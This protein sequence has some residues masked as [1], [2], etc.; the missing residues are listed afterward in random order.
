MTTELHTDYLIVG[1]GAVGMAFAD[2]L[3]AESDADVVII[4]RYERPGG[5]W[6]R[7]YPFVTLH[8][9]SQ[10]YGVRSME[11]SRGL[12]DRVG[13]NRGLYDLA[14]GHEVAAYFD[15]VMRHQ[16]LPTGR[17]RYFPLCDYSGDGNFRH[18]LTGEHYHVDHGMLADCTLLNTSIPSTHTPSFEIEDGVTFMPVNDLPKVTEP[19]AGFVVIGGGKTGID[20]VIWL[21][22]N[23]VDP[24]RITWIMPRD[25]W[26]LDRAKLQPG[27]EFFDATMGAQADQIEAIAAAGSFEDLFHRLEACGYFHRLDPQVEPTMFHAA[28]VSE[29]EANELRRVDDVVRLGRVQRITPT[30][31]VLDGGTVPTTPDHVFVD[32]SA[33]AIKVFEDR[34]VFEE[35]RIS[36]QTIRAY[37]PLFSASLIAYLELTRD[38]IEEKNR[39]SQVVPL[40]NHLEDYL[41]LTASNLINQFNWGQEADLGPWLRGNRLDGF[42]EAVAS[43]GPEDTE[44]AAVL[45]RIGASAFAAMGTLQRLMAE[46]DA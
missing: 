7:A 5:H 36:P 40:P 9:P 26:W 11:L 38:S 33:S 19:P 29:L 23:S 45:E 35:N 15:L 27:I 13:L 3:V 39:L 44:R 16:L 12:I 14:S 2:T 32:C 24:S 34:P 22:E 6:T 46:F 21:L 31:I 1:A 18:R 43:I 10:F 30:E 4:D 28:V 25:A 41:H 37:Q 17:V 8:Q 20:A 42:S